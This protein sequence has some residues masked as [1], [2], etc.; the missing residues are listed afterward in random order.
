M[1]IGNYLIFKRKRYIYKQNLLAESSSTNDRCCIAKSYT[2][3]PLPLPGANVAIQIPWDDFLSNNS[4][5]QPDKAPKLLPFPKDKLSSP[6]T[7]T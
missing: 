1:V 6:V 4:S 7:Q 3:H 2:N 5:Q